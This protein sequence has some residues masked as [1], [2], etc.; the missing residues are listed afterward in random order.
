MRKAYIHLFLIFYSKYIPFSFILIDE[1]N[2][3]NEDM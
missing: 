3:N 2:I 1:E